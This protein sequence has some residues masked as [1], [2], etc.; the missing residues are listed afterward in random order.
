M[1]RGEQWRKEGG[2]D[3]YGRKRKGRIILPNSIQIITQKE[4]QD[5]SHFLSKLPYPNRLL[6]ALTTMHPQETARL[7]TS[8]MV[9]GTVYISV[10]KD[11][12]GQCRG[13]LAASQPAS[14][15]AVLQGTVV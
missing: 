2:R 15:G 13:S 4:K 9:A 3:G 5:C 14:P 10:Q 8:V 6:P 12:Q 11:T 7:E 1:Y